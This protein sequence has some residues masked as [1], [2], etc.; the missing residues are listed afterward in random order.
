M[1]A[2]M[3]ACMQGHTCMTEGGMMLVQVLQ[4]SSERVWSVGG[5]T[6]SF[7]EFSFPTYPVGPSADQRLGLCKISTANVK[8]S[9]VRPA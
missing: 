7:T 9:T 2:C 3:H 6:V 5:A 1:H 4:E 8:A